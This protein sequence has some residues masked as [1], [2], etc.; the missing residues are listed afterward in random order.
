MSEAVDKEKR[1]VSE[2]IQIFMTYGIKSMTMDDI[3]R[4]MRM[5]KKTLY[6][7]VRDKNDLV[8]RCLDHD[9]QITITQI[10]ELLAEN[11]N[12]IEENFEISKNIVDDLKGIHPSIFYDLEKYYPEAWQ[13]MHGMRHDFVAEVMEANMKKGIAEG[14]YRKDLNVQIMTKLWVARLNVIFDPNF[15]DMNEF[16][17]IEVYKEMFMHHIRGIASKKGLEYIEK[18]QNK[19]N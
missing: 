9:C 15:F 8:K 12:A 11:L 6:Q 2:A 16:N 5:S 10:K 7:Y 13:T 4:H 1:I 19:L 3:A 17:I 18:H 14:L